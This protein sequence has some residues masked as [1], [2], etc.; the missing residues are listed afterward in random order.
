MHL[1]EAMKPGSFGLRGLKER[2][3]TV[4]GWL[5]ISSHEARGTTIILSVPLSANPQQYEEGGL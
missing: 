1:S 5:D 3:R 4:G 2:A